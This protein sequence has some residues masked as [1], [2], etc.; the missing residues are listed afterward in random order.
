MTDHPILSETRGSYRVITLNR[1]DRLNAFNDAMHVALRTAIAAAETDE[2]CRALLITGAGRGFCA[3]QD[4]NDRVVK[5]DEKP[6]PSNSL[7]QHYNPLVRKLRELPFPV[8]AAV[9]GVAAGAGCNI[10]LACDIVVAARSAKFIQSF[11]RIGL[12][13]DSGGTW[14]LPRLAGDARARGLALLAEPLSAETAEA[15]G[16]IWK[17]VDDADLRGEA[18]KMCA[19]FAAAPTQGLALIKRALNVSSGNTLDAQL[20]L[21]RDLQRLAHQTPDY[22][23]GVRAFVEKRKPHFTGRKES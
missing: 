19:H 21:E 23:E 12:V 20:D 10:A 15:W 17:C 11:A 8:I 9:N 5:P 14:V 3:G 22:A 18:D 6:A 13:P 16:L 1:P 2:N 7:E 4:L